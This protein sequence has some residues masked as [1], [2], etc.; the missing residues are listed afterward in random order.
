MP[1]VLAPP[2][3]APAPPPAPPAMPLLDAGG[4]A[5]TQLMREL[6]VPERLLTEAAGGPLAVFSQLPAAPPVPRAG[7]LV[8]VGER[9]LVHPRAV[10]LA[11]RMDARLVSLPAHRRVPPATVPR[12]LKKALVIALSTPRPGPVDARTPVRLAELTAQLAQ[13]DQL[14]EPVPVARWGVV[15]A[16]RKAED[17]AAWVGLVGGL[18]ALTV[19][20]CEG[21]ASPAT[22]LGAGVA[23]ALLDGRTASPELWSV[24]VAERRSDRD[25]R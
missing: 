25:Q 8:L 17:I 11:R 6:G 10:A 4:D 22:A 18:D 16:D 7:V 3:T 9:D 15:S 21:T 24:L 14:S 2:A 12:T 19:E 20:D 23:V 5:D 13:L 1:E